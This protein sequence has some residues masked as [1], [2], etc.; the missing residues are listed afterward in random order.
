[1]S[2]PPVDPRRPGQPQR[3]PLGQGLPLNP[4]TPLPAPTFT[5]DQ[6]ASAMMPPLQM[7][8]PAPPPPPPV[9][10]VMTAMMA[11]APPA[12]P[13]DPLAGLN[14]RDKPGYMPHWDDSIW[15]AVANA[16]QTHYDRLIRR[17]SRDVRLYRTAYSA[18][19]PDF[20]PKTEIA[21]RSA[22]VPNVVN[23]LTNMSSALDFRF[24]IP[25]RDETSKTQSQI[26]E[27]ACTYWRKCETI[28]YAETGGHSSL[29]W[30]EFFYL[31]LFGRVCKRILPAPHRT[32]GHP[33]DIEL[34]D[35]S[36]VFPVWGGTNEG[37]IRITH[38]RSMSAIDV[39]STY[40]RYAPN[41]PAR[42]KQAMSETWD[43]SDD[44][45]MW[46]QQGELIEGWNSW[47]RWVSWRG[48]TI[49]ETDHK[50][51]YVP[52]VY[53]MAKGE[54]RGMTTPLGGYYDAME[55]NDAEDVV[56]RGVNE[57]EDEAEKGVSVFHH[58]VQ[59]NR[60][61]EIFYTILVNETLK[62]Q[63]PPTITYAAPQ[64]AGQAP[65]PLSYKRKANNQRVL[66]AQRVEIAPTSPRPTDISPVLNKLSGDITEGS[67]NPAMYGGVEGSNIA[68][69]AI[70]SMIAAA[71]DTIL[72]Y[73]RGFE[74]AQQVQAR[75][76]LMQYR[77]HIL[78]VHSVSIPMEGRYG[79]AAT[80]DLT[81]EV[82]DG[83][84]TK[85]SCEVVG[86]SDQSL[87]MLVNAAGAAVERG[88]W[89]RRKAMEKLG[90]KDPGRMISE[91]IIERALEHP[92]MMENFLI[93]INF[94]RAGQKDLADLWV[95]MIVMP[96]IQMLMSKMLGPQG[97]GAGG[98]MAGMQAAMGGPP[99]AP[100]GMPPGMPGMPPGMPA[101]GAGG[102]EQ[103]GQSN[104]MAGRAM[105]PP[106][107]PEAGQGRGPA[108]QAPP[109]ALG[110]AR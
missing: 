27:N 64:M 67:I 93:P 30:D 83:A 56:V 72:P 44:P 3:P 84:G 40:S 28:G 7:G 60:M 108:P 76:Q 63:D 12:P 68:G 57:A 95:L 26:A 33:F 45:A 54:P 50:L 79:T 89:S 17:F 8:M 36:T 29:Q 19:P 24:I 101:M 34:I 110:N 13:F 77:S 81:R 51:G 35:P 62:S 58:I 37:L 96:K 69:F 94:I 100:P 10:P 87:P 4:G 11:N 55:W 49:L 78:P 15:L 90:E 53:V 22:T 21:F 52:F 98:P 20:D 92:E 104:P 109:I 9:D 23:K 46:H 2:F 1:M 66:N 61:V 71:K 31:F 99:G 82:M 107:G 41:L 32:D 105:G 86:V 97:A 70:E 102:M 38:R 25:F 16:D 43:V 65:P 88:F 14:D 6:A 106:T 18:T 47:S 103:N 91:I 42:L 80:A 85:V 75:I 48:V 59:T 39:V 73:L 5:A 74:I